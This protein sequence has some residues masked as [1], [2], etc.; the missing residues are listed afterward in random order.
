MRPENFNIVSQIE[1][2]ITKAGYRSVSGSAAASKK[3]L[4]AGLDAGSASGSISQIRSG[5][6]KRDHHHHGGGGGGSFFEASDL[7]SS[8]AAVGSMVEE[9]AQNLRL[10]PGSLRAKSAAAVGAAASSQGGGNATTAG[11]VREEGDDPSAI[12]YQDDGHIGASAADAAGGR[13]LGDDEEQFMTLLSE[14][15]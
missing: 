15:K 13:S 10:R 12:D 7:E 9:A 5:S 1:A 3:D 4:S 8:T 2:A 6:C 14:I 11:R